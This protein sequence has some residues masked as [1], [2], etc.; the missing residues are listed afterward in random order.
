MERFA[1]NPKQIPSL[2]HCILYS[3]QTT[4]HVDI[5]VVGGIAM[6]L[7]G[8]PRYTNDLDAEVVSGEHLEALQ[9]FLEKNGILANLSE[10]ISGWGIVPLPGD[11]RAKSKT[12]YSDGKITI[13][14][15]DPVDFVISKLRRGTDEDLE[16]IEH[17]VKRFKLSPADVERR[18]M[19]IEWRK[20]QETLFFKK[21]LEAFLRRAS[22]N[23]VRGAEDQSHDRG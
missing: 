15:L 23:E 2:R 13:R 5:L 14:T 6:A 7:Y 1:V 3:K 22:S 19:E 21:R 17:V 9:K 8:L 16:D 11:Y 18:C 4:T 20:D 12:L 10:N